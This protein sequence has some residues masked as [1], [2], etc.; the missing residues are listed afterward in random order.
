MM[1]ML[2]FSFSFLN[3]QVNRCGTTEY[4]NWLM[5]Q[6]PQLETKIQE[7]DV[8]TQNIL[9]QE[10][11]YLSS[12]TITV[13]PTVVHIVWNTSSQNISDAMI[14]SQIEILNEDFRRMQGTNGWNTHPDGDDTKY[15]WRLAAVDP[16][17][18]PT[19]GITRTFTTIGSFGTI[20]L[21]FLFSFKSSASG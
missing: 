11:D 14:E 12:E 10:P 19:N 4:M 3:A 15:E 16:N 21:F 9:Q 5:Q 18:D 17:G 20:P 2:L 1:F 8:Q 13:I 7:M 6:D